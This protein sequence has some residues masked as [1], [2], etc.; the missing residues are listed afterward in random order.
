MNAR[1]TEQINNKIKR[2]NPSNIIGPTRAPNFGYGE[3]LN[4]M[5]IVLAVM[6]ARMAIRDTKLV[7]VVSPGKES[8]LYL[9]TNDTEILGR[10]K[11]HH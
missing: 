9:S 5:A 2:G 10:N 8:F 4:V 6:F 1:S 11:T 7:E 3:S